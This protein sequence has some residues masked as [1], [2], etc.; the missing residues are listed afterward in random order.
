MKT[1]RMPLLA[2]LLIVTFLIFP[3][4]AYALTYGVGG[5]DESTVNYQQSHGTYGLIEVYNASVPA[6]SSAHV[7]SLYVWDFS[8]S[9][10]THAE[11]GWVQFYR[12]SPQ[13][14]AAWY[15]YGTY[16]E[17]LGPNASLGGHS[18]KA[19]N[20][21]GTNQWQMY[22]DSNLLASHTY[23]H[24]PFSF[25]SSVVG[26]ERNTTQDQN[27]SHFWD[28]Q[29]FKNGAWNLWYSMTGFTDNDPDYYLN[30]KSSHDAYVTK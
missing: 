12:K 13:A 24:V 22:I 2:M 16:G 8:R 14:F 27:D 17:Y 5:R 6:S 15:D 29:V 10:T 26:S 7:G 25:G 3:I 20:I 1:S 19:V 28:L 30:I 18:F 4:S 11:S 9:A 23:T 21:L